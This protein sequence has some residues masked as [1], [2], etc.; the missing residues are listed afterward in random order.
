MSDESPPP[1]PGVPPAWQG[2]GGHGAP[3]PYG[4]PGPAGPY[5]P[6]APYGGYP[7]Y[8]PAGYGAGWP[9]WPPQAPRNKLGTSSLVL[10][11][12]GAAAGLTVVGSLLGVPLGVLALVFGIVGRRRARRGGATNGGQ[13][14]AGAI[15]GGV[16][17]AVSVVLLVVVAVHLDHDLPAKDPK[18]ALTSSRGAADQPLA[19]ATTATYA[20][21]TWVTVGVP[22][23]FT[24]PADVRGHTPGASAYEV[25]VTVDETGPGDLALSGYGWQADAL[26]PGG[27]QRRLKLITAADGPLS[28]DFPAAVGSGDTVKVDFAFDVPAGADA[29][30]FG[31]RPAPRFAGAHWLLHPGA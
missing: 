22:R 24:P 29:V 15:L 17:A 9:G 11:I 28:H 25:G 10:G 3:G 18:V 13:A 2:T 5:G 21:G 26:E 19:P 14:L 31:F 7:P 12:V 30:G 16:A 20:D 8:G 1:Q 4:P 23:R 27:G 6:Y